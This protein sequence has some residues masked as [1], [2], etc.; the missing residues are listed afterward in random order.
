MMV[1]KRDNKVKSC[2]ATINVSACASIKSITFK[3][4]C[5]SNAV[6]GSSK[7]HVD[8]VSFNNILVIAKR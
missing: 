2:V 5:L 3:L 8:A 1:S 7:I 4:F 6:V